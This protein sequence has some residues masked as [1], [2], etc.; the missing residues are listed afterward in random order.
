MSPKHVMGFAYENIW[1]WTSRQ[2]ESTGESLGCE[3]LR[4][5]INH[6][7]LKGSRGASGSNTGPVFTQKG[8]KTHSFTYHSTQQIFHSRSCSSEI[9]QIQPALLCLKWQHQ[10]PCDQEV[11]QIIV[12]GG[13]CGCDSWLLSHIVLG[14]SREGG[15]KSPFSPVKP[16]TH[17]LLMN[18]FRENKAQFLMKHDSQ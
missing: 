15:K 10:L 8:I 13:V 5:A 1:R 18:S 11:R 9:T 6:G 3:L 12:S 14:L 4:L 16:L 7:A 2:L 17:W